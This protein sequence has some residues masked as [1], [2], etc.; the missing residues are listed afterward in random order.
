M[1]R[2]TMF[3]NCNLQYSINVVEFFQLRSLA[4]KNE[5]FGIGAT[6]SPGG[7]DGVDLCRTW[8]SGRQQAPPACREAQMGSPHW[9]RWPPPIVL[10]P[11]WIDGSSSSR[12]PEDA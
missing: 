7:T 4:R 11:R 5:D 3:E 6:K 9:F 10:A 8:S 12:A 2:L 1:L